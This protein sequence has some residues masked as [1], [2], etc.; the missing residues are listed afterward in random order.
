MAYASVTTKPRQAFNHDHKKGE[1]KA[2]A[3][4]A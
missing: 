4:W 1:K 3:K 2:A